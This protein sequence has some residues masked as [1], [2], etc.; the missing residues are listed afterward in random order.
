MGEKGTG[1]I[2][3]MNGQKGQVTKRKVERAKG[4]RPPKSRLATKEQIPNE[5]R[6]QKEG[7]TKKG[8]GRITGCGLIELR[9]ADLFQSAG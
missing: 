9:D 7:T 2:L 1:Q 8:T 4:D 6:S 5:G 3:G